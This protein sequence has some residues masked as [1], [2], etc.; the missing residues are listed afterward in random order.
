MN[1]AK[2]LLTDV[3]KKLTNRVD[4]RTTTLK[5]VRNLSVSDLEMLELYA[6]TIIQEGRYTGFLMEPLGGVGEVMNK[7]GLLEKGA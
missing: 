3:R 4:Y 2:K 7:Y 6:Q 1:G 5:G